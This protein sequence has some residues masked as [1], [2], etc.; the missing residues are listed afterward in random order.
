MS[1]ISIKHYINTELKPQKE[2]G[3]LKYPLYVQVIYKRKVFKFKSNYD[4]FQYLAEEDIQNEFIQS[5][6]I[7]EKNNILKTIDLLERFDNNFINGKNIAILSKPFYNIIEENM[8]KLIAKEIPTAPLFFKT[9]TY[10]EINDVICFLGSGGFI[11]HSVKIDEIM[12]IIGNMGYPTYD[13]HKENYLAVDFY[14]GEKLK[15]IINIILFT[16]YDSEDNNKL[17]EILENFRELINL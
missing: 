14:T 1:K 3:K 11:E 17:F 2:N 10:S 6:L 9:S 8:C 4:V 7:T 16:G 12:Q 15:E 5:M 13:F